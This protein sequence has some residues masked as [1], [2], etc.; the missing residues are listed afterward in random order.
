MRKIAILVLLTG[1]CMISFSQILTFTRKFETVGKNVPMAIINSHPDFFYLL[2]YNKSIHDFTVEQRSKPTAE[3][4]GFTA[5]KL[6][7]INSDWFDYTKLDYLFFEQD[8]KLYFVFERVLNTKKTIYLKIIDTLHKSRGFIE[9]ETLNAEKGMLDFAF[10]FKT[11]FNNNILIIASRRY[12]NATNKTVILFNIQKAKIEWRN[13]LPI[14]NDYT[15]YS[16]EFLCNEK[17]DLFYLRSKTHV[18]SF[19]RKYMHQMQ[20]QLPVVFYDNITLTALLHNEPTIIHSIPILNNV[21]RLNKIVLS[22]ADNGILVQAHYAI[23]EEES[24]YKKVF[25]SSTKLSDD[26]STILYSQTTS[27]NKDREQQLTFYDGTDSKYAGDKHYSLVSKHGNENYD[28]QI[29]E[30]LDDAAYKELLVIGTDIKTGNI[31][32]QHVIMRKGAW[33]ATTAFFNG[34]LNIVTNEAPSNFKKSTAESKYH[35]F[36]KESFFW[37]SNIVM[38]TITDKGEITK[39]LVSDNSNLNFAHPNYSGD[40]Q[41]TIIFCEEKNGYERFATLSLDTL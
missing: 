16:H 34:N 36:K 24:R 26:L 31:F 1:C 41:N 11:T 33:P 15:G 28:F 2:R 25:L 7:Q 3:I 30:R 22:A 4:I 6:D 17:M 9:I 27:L 40:N 38:Y 39:T 29:S 18:A 35:K 23:E 5:L 19:E 20:M 12:H 14:E 32:T 10:E 13:K 21:D 37:G 8:K